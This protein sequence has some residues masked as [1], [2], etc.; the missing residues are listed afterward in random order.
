MKL[1]VVLTQ[2][3]L[4]LGKRGEVVKV[5]PGYA[6]N[7][8]LPNLKA[9]LAT[10]SNLKSFKEENERQSKEAL[11]RRATA[12]ALAKKIDTASV[13]IEVLV[14]DGEKLYGAI[15][16]QDI[17]QA[18]SH[19]GVL[20]DKKDIH[21]ES[22]IKQLGTYEVAVKLYPEVAAKLKLWVIKKKNG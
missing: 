11:N 22:P 19:Q 17:Q 1:E 4:K 3:D 10:P 2:D 16:S 12:E 7:F 21:L 8:L 5:S 9:K 20:V 14:G 13:T 6:H 15:T 18:L